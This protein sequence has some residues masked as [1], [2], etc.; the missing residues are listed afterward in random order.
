VDALAC[1]LPNAPCRAS[2]VS[3]RATNLATLTASLSV[4]PDSGRP[5]TQA[6]ARVYA[7]AVNLRGYDAPQMK[8]AGSERPVDDRNYREAFARCAGELRSPHAVVEMR[9]PT[10]WS[11]GRL[12]YDVVSS[13]VAVSPSETIANRY[14]AVLASG[15]ARACITHGYDR[16]LLR[17]A[18]ERDELVS[19]GS[20]LRDWRPELPPAIGASTR[21]VEPR[22][23]S[24]YRPATRTAGAS[25]SSY[26]STSKASYLPAADQESA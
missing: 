13:T 2:A 5:I 6:Q 24:R 8:R 16:L 14:L 10:F 3:A 9:S 25:A 23:D 12:H 18:G 21:S 4:Q 15:H 22:C 1:A 26:P 17:R 19:A 20:P 7:H 11:H